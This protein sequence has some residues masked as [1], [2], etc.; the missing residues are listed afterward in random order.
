[1][2]FHHSTLAHQYLFCLFFHLFS[3][4]NLQFWHFSMNCNLI[5]CF[6]G[7]HSP[8]FTLSMT[9]SYSIVICSNQ[10]FKPNWGITS[11]G[12]ESRN[13]QMTFQVVYSPGSSFSIGHFPHLD[14]HHIGYLKFYPRGLRLKNCCY[15]FSF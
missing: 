7:L 13:T 3:S 5:H 2:L 15:S 11:S 6:C 9:L 1:M 4:F 14:C 8:F 12:Y 10:L